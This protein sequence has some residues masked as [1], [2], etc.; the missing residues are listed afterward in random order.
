MDVTTLRRR[1]WYFLGAALGILPLAIWAAALDRESVASLLAVLSVGGLVAFVFTRNLI[2]RR[3]AWQEAAGGTV[4]KKPTWR[5]PA[6]IVIASLVIAGMLAST[7]DPFA[8]FV[9][10]GCGV[11]SVLMAAVRVRGK[12]AVAI[13]HLVAAA[14]YGMAVATIQ[15]SSTTV[16]KDADMIVRKLEEYRKQ[17]G[18]YPDRLDALVPAMLPAIPKP[19]PSGFI[20]SKSQDSYTLYHRSV[21]ETCS[22]RPSKPVRE[23]RPN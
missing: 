14:I 22:Y 3:L 21:A 12:R 23:C 5:T 4:G 15:F 1:S 6:A 2:L 11:V 16:P 18:N 7:G 17:Y 19:G 13:S 20:Y 8:A 10:G 9:L